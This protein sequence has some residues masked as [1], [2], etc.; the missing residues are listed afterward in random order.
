MLPLYYDSNSPPFE[1]LLDMLKQ[2]AI[3][4]LEEVVKEVAD[5]F[6]AGDRLEFRFISANRYDFSR[7]SRMLASIPE[8]FPDSP[9]KAKRCIFD[10]YEK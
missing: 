9:L 5:L 7:F 10:W 3:V 1:A 6:E 4:T 2:A 8:S